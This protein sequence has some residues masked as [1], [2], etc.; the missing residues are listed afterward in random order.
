[1]NI[2]SLLAVSPIDGRYSNKCSELQEIFSE[3]GLIKRR[4][5]VECTW[6][7]ALAADPKIR[8][9]EGGRQGRRRVL[10][11]GRAARQGHR[12][13]HQPRRQGRRVLPQGE[14]L[15]SLQPPNLKRQTS[16]LKHS[17]VHPLRLHLRGH[18][19]HVARADA[20]GRT[21]GPQGRDGRDDGEGRRDGE[22]LREGA[23]A[24]AHARPARIPDDGRQGACGREP[25]PEASGGRDRP[26]RDA[27]EDERR[28]RQL[29]RT[30]LRVSRRRLGEALRQGHQDARAPSEPPDDADREP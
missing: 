6:L 7:K 28:G 5:L 9:G 26:A 24:R 13:D 17:R 2:D 8:A 10:P 20:A 29:Q 25:A 18:Q 19:Q 16:D 1:M 30:P 23:D 14:T 27:G 4:V 15:R 11:G 3:F 22:G 12:E 21:E